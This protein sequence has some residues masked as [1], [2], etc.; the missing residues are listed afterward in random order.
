MENKIKL[1]VV[2]TE[3]EAE[4]FFN[5]IGMASTEPSDVDYKEQLSIQNKFT[6]A[7]EKNRV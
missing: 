1:S 5:M 7:R 3:K 4:V 2:L 6:K